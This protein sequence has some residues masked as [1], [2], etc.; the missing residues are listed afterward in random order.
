M[1]PREPRVSGILM[2]CI[3]P[4]PRHQERG[5]ASH[6]LYCILGLFPPNHQSAWQAKGRLTR[7]KGARKR[8]RSGP[9]FVS[10]LPSPAQQPISKACHLQADAS[11]PTRPVIAAIDRE[12]YTYTP[13]CNRPSGKARQRC[14]RRKGAHSSTDGHGQVPSS[15]HATNSV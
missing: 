7:S 13:S 10:M 3:L 11:A 4:I 14:C 12:A 15:C 8:R 9:D 5:A 2:P 6:P 1:L